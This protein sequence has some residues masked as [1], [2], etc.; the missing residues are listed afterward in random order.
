[1]TMITAVITSSIA[2]VLLIG[3]L[4]AVYQSRRR[5]SRRRR[6]L[7]LTLHVGTSV[8]WL[9]AAIA[10]TVLLVAGLVT[11]NPAL[12]HSAFTFMHVYDL[13]VMIPLG[14]LALITGAL[15]SVGTNWGLLKHWWIVT[16]LVL[17]VAVLVFAG[18]FTSGWVLEGVARTAEDPMADLGVLAAQLVANVV[19]FNVVFWTNT[20]IS[21]FKPWGPTPRGQHKLAQQAFAKQALATSQ[22]TERRGQVDVGGV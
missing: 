20:T 19:A 7:V 12:R 16:K 17:T 8:G 1:M 10:M 9:G 6:K 13:A 21:V 14:Y 2:L 22:R 3:L 5:M 18:V 11:R 15:L 4:L